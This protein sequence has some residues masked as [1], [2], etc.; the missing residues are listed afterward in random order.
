MN[1]NDPQL[2][3]DLRRDEA[4]RYVPYKDTVGIDTVGV[5]HNMKAHP[6]PAE[7]NFP[8]TDEQVN[9]LLSEDL[10]RVFSGLDA[11]LGWWRT[12]SENRQ[13]VLANMAFNLGMQGLLGFHNTLQFIQDGAYEDAAKGML[14]SKWAKQVG[15]RANRL[16]DTMVQG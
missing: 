5:G 15:Q 14:S 1:P 2:I 16:A 4:V 11:N 6:L 12:L 7:W 10:V 8:L 9:Q 13:R 3:S